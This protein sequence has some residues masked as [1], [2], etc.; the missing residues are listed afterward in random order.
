MFGVWLRVRPSAR[1]PRSSRI[2]TP[3]THT[4]STVRFAVH[5]LYDHD[6]QFRTPMTHTE[7]T[8]R[9]AVHVPY[10]HDTQ[11]RTPMTHTES[12]VRF[13]VHALACIRCF[14][15]MQDSPGLINASRRGV[16]RPNSRKPRKLSVSGSSMAPYSC[17]SV[18]AFSS[19]IFCIVNTVECTTTVREA[20]IDMNMFQP[21]TFAA[22]FGY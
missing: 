17:A 20:L 11:Y 18:L 19:S 1:G 15:L 3:M 16:S 6:T 13:A 10:D 8:V 7:S 12:T 21:N 4:V 5:V 2:L 22:C 9:F 14:C